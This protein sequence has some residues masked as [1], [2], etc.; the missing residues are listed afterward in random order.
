MLPFVNCYQLYYYILS[1]HNLFVL[2]LAQKKDFCSA[3][4]RLKLNTKIGLHTTHH[5]TNSQA[6]IS[7]L[8]VA[9]FGPNFKQR[10]LGTY[11][12]DNNCHHYICPGNIC[13]GDICPY[14]QYFSCYWPVFFYQT[15]NQGSWEHK[16]QITS[17]TTTFALATFVL[18][19]FVHIENISISKRNTFDI[20]L[21][22]IK[23]LIL[24]DNLSLLGLNQID[25][26]PFVIQC[27]LLVYPP[28]PL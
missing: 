6:A 8:L 26:P 14:Q 2:I 9:R 7:Q 28:S 16:H 17:V 22:I 4:P 12:T 24:F 23:I 21:V 18:G 20:S 25:P 11:T 13:P 27:N 5:H 3:W 15:L 1:E 10:V 19:T